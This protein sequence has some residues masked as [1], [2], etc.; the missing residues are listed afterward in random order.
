M[1]WKTTR[2]E[3]EEERRGEERRGEEETSCGGGELVI[4]DATRSQ[5]KYRF[6]SSAQRSKPPD[7]QI[8]RGLT[9]DRCPLI[10]FCPHPH[11]SSSF[12]LFLSRHPLLFLS[13]LW[14]GAERGIYS[15]PQPA[16]GLLCVFWI[17]A[18][19]RVYEP[20]TR[21]SAGGTEG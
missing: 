2:R 16:E 4:K 13:S 21:R 11:P 20:P 5:V 6:C 15:N 18:G 19:V 10:L 17:R 1:G 7:R 9:E 12:L 3:E 14:C 8:D